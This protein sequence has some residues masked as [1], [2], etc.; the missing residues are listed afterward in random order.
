MGIGVGAI[1]AIAIEVEVEDVRRGTDTS[2]IRDWIVGYIGEPT[3]TMSW[4]EYVEM[5]C[6]LLWEVYEQSNFSLSDESLDALKSELLNMIIEVYEGVDPKTVV[7][8]IE[9]HCPP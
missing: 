9:R 6:T 7:R 5:Y 8:V 3:V 1:E 2:R 4:E